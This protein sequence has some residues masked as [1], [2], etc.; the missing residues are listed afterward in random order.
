MKVTF[1]PL[2][3]SI[4]VDVGMSILEAALE[5]GVNLDHNCG[6]VCACTTCHVIVKRGDDS[7]SEI[8]DAED[9]RLSQA[10]GLTLHS[11]LGC[12]AVVE[13]GDE[14]VTVEIPNQVPVWERA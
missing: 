6:G 13:S 12:Q 10:E 14:D 5:N 1:L 9:D 11:R 7:L 2:N 3:I 8:D 4:E